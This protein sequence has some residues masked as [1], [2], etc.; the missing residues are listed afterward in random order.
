M[1]DWR[2]WMARHAF[3]RRLFLAAAGTAVSVAGLF[4]RAPEA[5]AVRMRRTTGMTA[6][7]FSFV[8]IDDQALPLAQFRGRSLLVVNTASF[9]GYTPQYAGLERLWQSYRDRGLVVL[10][11]PSNDFGQQEPGTSREIRAFCDT[12]AVSF[13]L[14]RRERVTGAEAHPFYRWIASELGEE[15]LPRWNF[16]KVLVDREGAL[17][18]AWPSQVEP[19]APELLRAVEAALTQ[20]RS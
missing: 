6:F 15:S 12:F 9:C 20:E 1:S 8:A 4:T 19:M 13:P 5:R 2:L 3:T 10:G 7:D 14:S 16:H 17:V 11:V 18:G